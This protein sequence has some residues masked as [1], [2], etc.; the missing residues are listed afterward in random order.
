MAAP[1]FTIKRGDRLPALRATLLRSDGTAQ[2]LS[3][4]TAQVFIYQDEDQASAAVVGTGTVVV[5]DAVAGIVEY[6][7]A[8][9]DTA[10][11]GRFLG[12]FEIQFGAGV[13]LTFPNGGFILFDVVADL[14]DGP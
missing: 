5:V 13:R 9:A 1:D 4:A 11:A 14:S 8:T 12:E 2:D 10:N 3:A 6:P 7:W